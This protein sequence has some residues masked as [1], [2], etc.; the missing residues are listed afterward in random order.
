MPAANL[1]VERWAQAVYGKEYNK[2]ETEKRSQPR[3]AGIDKTAD[4][5]LMAPK[6][7]CF[8]RARRIASR[9]F[10]DRLAHIFVKIFTGKLRGPR[11]Q[12]RKRLRKH[13]D[14]NRRMKIEHERMRYLNVT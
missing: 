14:N 5:R 2:N 13:E 12:K 10:I 9:Q 4:D 1:P 11:Y 7:R 8:L 3:E 6:L